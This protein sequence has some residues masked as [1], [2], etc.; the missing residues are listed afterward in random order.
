[1]AAT[2]RRAG[3]W[4]E[5]EVHDPRCDGVGHDCD[6]HQRGDDHSLTNLRWLNR[7]CHKAKTAREAADGRSAQRERNREPHPGVISP[8]A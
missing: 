3:G 8:G 1:M 4:C 2:K 7:W 5:A 6:H